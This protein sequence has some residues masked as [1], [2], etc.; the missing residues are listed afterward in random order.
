VREIVPL[1]IVVGCDEVNYSPSLAGDCVICALVNVGKKVEGVKD[2]KLLTLKK[3]LN[4]FPLI[5]ENSIFSISIATF[6]DVEILGIYEARNYAALSALEQVFRLLV[7]EKVFQNSYRTIK[8][9]IDG[10]WSREKKEWFKSSLV[11]ATGV[12]SS[13]EGVVDGDA[14]V[15]EISAASI[16]ARVYCDALFEGWNTFFPGYELNT[17][18]GSVTEKHKT[19][20]REKGPS[21][22]HRVKNYGKSWWKSILGEEECQKLEI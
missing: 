4:L 10:H 15:Y 14:T 19:T 21:P 5:A 22:V 11:A 2:S 12:S 20:L 17:N 1:E 6:K 9:L 8:V 13:V 18:H 16:I 3:R 7:K